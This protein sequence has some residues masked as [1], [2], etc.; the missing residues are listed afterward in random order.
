MV[1]VRCIEILYKKDPVLVKQ[2]VTDVLMKPLLELCCSEVRTESEEKIVVTEDE[3]SLCISNMHRL[4]VECNG[5]VD[6]A[7]HPAVLAT[8]TPILIS[9]YKKI[10]SS[11]SHIKPTVE[12][13][14]IKILYSLKVDVLG[15]VFRSI[16]FD[17][18]ISCKDMLQINNIYT[19]SFGPSGGVQ[20]EVKDKTEHKAASLK[21]YFEG[22]AD[23]TFE[24]LN[25]GDKTGEITTNLF[26]ILLHVFFDPLKDDVSN[27]GGEKK[28]QNLESSMCESDRNMVA[29]HLLTALSDSHFV[30]EKICSDPNYLVRYIFFILERDAKQLIEKPEGDDSDE[31]LVEH[32]FIVLMILSVAVSSSANSPIEG[33]L[34]ESIVEPLRMIRDSMANEELRNLASQIYNKVVTHGV[35]QESTLNK[36]KEA[37]SDKKA[38]CSNKKLR[39]KSYEAHNDACKNS[40]KSGKGLDS[41]PKEKS[42]CL[43]AVMDS[44]DPMIPVKGHGLVKLGRLIISGDEEIRKHKN[45]VFLIFQVIYNMHSGICLH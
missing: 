22:G 45:K 38:D 35:V 12:E 14:L 15:G 36:K 6:P 26:L 4:F 34:F 25:K 13:L 16:I 9:L 23:C 31:P 8:F 7:L 2:H 5:T 27:A 1:A 24:L 19:F 41:K 17:D 20:V 33:A 43:K 11:P 40:E 18:E 37:P 29:A 42:A 3:L 32:L 10:F 21:E 28:S 39:K 30:R 44:C